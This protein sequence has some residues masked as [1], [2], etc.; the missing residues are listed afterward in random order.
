MDGV[1]K[2][3]GQSRIIVSRPSYGTGIAPSQ[4]IH[5]CNCT[6]SGQLWST[7]QTTHGSDSFSICLRHLGSGRVLSII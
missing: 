2:A 5:Y 6:W 7:P 4:G 1:L 3:Q